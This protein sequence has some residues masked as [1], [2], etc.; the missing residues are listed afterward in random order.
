MNAISLRN[1]PQPLTVPELCDRHQDAKLD[2][3]ALQ[4][5][6]EECAANPWGIANAAGPMIEE[7]IE[8]LRGAE[9][10]IFHLERQVEALIHDQQSE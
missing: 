8:H 9:T 4:E 3:D 10:R 6:A 1:A 2:L 7:L 5:Q